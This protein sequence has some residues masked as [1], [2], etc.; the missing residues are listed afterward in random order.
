MKNPS[1]QRLAYIVVLSV[2]TTLGLSGC[3]L[4][5]PPLS[6]HTS[7]LRDVKVSPV[8]LPSPARAEQALA[9]GR[10]ALDEGREGQAIESFQRALDG[11]AASAAALNGMGVAY[12][13]LGRAET[14]RDLFAQA[15]AMDPPN[16]RYADNLALLSQQIAMARPAPPATSTP[17]PRAAAR[18]DAPP[19]GVG[20]ATPPEAPRLARV[21]PHEFALRTLP[22]GPAPR[23]APGPANAPTGMTIVSGTVR[24]A[25][26]DRGNDRG[27]TRPDSARHLVYNPYAQV[28]EARIEAFG[29]LIWKTVLATPG[30]GHLASTRAT[31]LA[32]ATPPARRAQ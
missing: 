19:T 9:E 24:A 20:I 12:A 26:N 16:A 15:L 14:A 13:R 21:A 32:A 31:I 3:S 18:G 27:A 28:A 11:G 17:P 22:P 5:R 7:A 1:R 8:G 10:Q 2:A 29:R 6:A 30:V 25:S 4:F 23:F